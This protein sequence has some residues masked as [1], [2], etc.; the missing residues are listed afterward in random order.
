LYRLV[1]DLHQP[2]LDRSRPLW[3]V[4]VIDGL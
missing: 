2:M 1:S 3:E 4:H